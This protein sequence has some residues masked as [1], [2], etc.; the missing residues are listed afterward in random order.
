[1]LE[2]TDSGHG[3]A[4]GDCDRAFERFYRGTSHGDVE[5]SC[6][7]LA[8][9]KRAVERAHRQITLTSE[10][11]RGTAVRIYLPRPIRA[12]QAQV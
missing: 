1:M 10:L 11:G 4:A 8:I 2:I 5:G 3:M 12:A 6:L 9:A 7:G